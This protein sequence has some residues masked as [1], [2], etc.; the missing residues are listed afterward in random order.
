[1]EDKKKLLLAGGGYA[2]IPLIRAAQDLGYYVVT[3]GNR[4]EE[5]GHDVSDEYRPADFSDREEMLDLARDL[6]IEAICPCCNDF[7]AISS[8]YVAEQLGLPGYDSY[9]TSQLI[10]HK[11]TYRKFALDNDIPTPFAKGFDDFE[12]ALSFIGN[13]RFPLIIKPVDLTGGKGITKVT[14]QFEVKSALEDAFAITR[15]GRVVIEEFIE[16]S[17]H[18]FSAFIRDGK[19]VF[20]FTDN[21]H[22]YLNQY[23]VS[24]ASTPS[25]VPEG[26]VQALVVQSEKIAELLA[27]KTGIFHVQFILRDDEPVIIEIC[28]RPPGDLYI[29]LVEHATGIDYPTWIVRAS[30]GLDCSELNQK[31]VDGFYLRHCVMAS[32]QGFLESVVIDSSISKNII[33]SM[34]WWRPGDKVENYLVTKFGIVFLKFDSLDELLIKSEKMHELIRAN[35]KPM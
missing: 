31:E 35:I 10:H 12:T 26:A 33:D 27:L 32:Q 29:K 11:D 30:C 24:A 2:D 7:S 21:E 17:R 23:M 1:L 22:Y 9:E 4:P 6:G 20:Y 34:M 14:D 13:F 3:T 5:L 15:L 8:A 25:T 19:V 18:G 16:G 28:R